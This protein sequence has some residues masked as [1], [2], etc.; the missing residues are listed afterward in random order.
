MVLLATCLSP[1]HPS[2]SNG[3]WQVKLEEF[4][5]NAIQVGDRRGRPSAWDHIK[6][7]IG[8][9]ITKGFSWPPSEAADAAKRRKKWAERKRVPAK[10][11]SPAQQSV[12]ESIQ[13]G[14]EA[15]S[16]DQIDRADRQ[17]YM[18]LTGKNPTPEQLTKWRADRAK[19]E[20]SFDR[21]MKDGR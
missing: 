3:R 5:P 11:A 4:D 7:V 1:A 6:G 16:R 17:E 20:A 12:M 18:A 10:P 8:P 9:A 15:T 19:A 13:L 21:I 2:A 14:I